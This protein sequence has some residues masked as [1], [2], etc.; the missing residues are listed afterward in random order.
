MMECH[1]YQ[2]PEQHRPAAV[3]PVAAL[4]PK[5]QMQID[6][7]QAARPALLIHAWSHFH[8]VPIMYGTIPRRLRMASASP[9]LLGPL[10][11]FF[12][13]GLASGVEGDASTGGASPRAA[14]VKGIRC[15]HIWKHPLHHR[16]PASASRLR[17]RFSLMRSALPSLLRCGALGSAGDVS[18][19]CSTAATLG[20]LLLGAGLGASVGGWLPGCGQH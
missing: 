16:Q 4:S 12:G 6:P 9:A 20:C 14:V 5:S 15:T 1:C 18:V 3:H 19:L 8:T 11:T 7:L 10:T 2:C 13:A 17:L